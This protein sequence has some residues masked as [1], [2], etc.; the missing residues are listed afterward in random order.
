MLC[1][2]FFLQTFRS[3]IFNSINQHFYRDFDDRQ[4][5][6]LPTIINLILLTIL[7]IANCFVNCNGALYIGVSKMICNTHHSPSVPSNPITTI[8]M[9]IT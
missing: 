2:P 8:G 9:V 5:A 1:K 7:R 6:I 4:W 3:N